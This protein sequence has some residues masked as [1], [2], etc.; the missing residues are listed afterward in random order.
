MTLP[1]FLIIG[2]P[3]AGTTSL[4]NYLSAHPEIQMSAMKEPNFFAPHL[5]A[6]HE[7]RRIRDLG[8]Y[9]RLFD[10]TADVRG[11]SSTPYAEYP[12]RQGVPERIAG[13]I[14]DAKLIY[15]MRD[16][17]ARTISHHGHMVASEGERSTLREALADLS[18]PR[19]PWICASLYGLQLDLYLRAFSIDQILV[20]DQ[21]DL[22]TER[23]ATLRRIFEFLEVDPAFESDDF[24]QEYLQASRRHRYPPGFG[25]FVDSQVV[26]RMLWVPQRTRT[27]LRHTVER[28]FF[29]AHRPDPVDE[30][31]RA[32]LIEYFTSEAERV[33]SLTGQSF[34]TWSV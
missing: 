4:H 8:D 28:T 19:P 11:E 24:D 26:P 13:L 12:L 17:V 23:R 15:M 29:P 9:E 34:P 21:A 18:D 22:L 3:K 31:S 1:T 27:T 2:A 33:R 32:R 5:Q 20:V 10:A 7:P 6:V 25:R 30:E 14:P 16:P